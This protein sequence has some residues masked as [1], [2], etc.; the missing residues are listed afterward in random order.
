MTDTRYP[1]Y[2]TCQGHF[3]SF[4]FLFFS[5]LNDEVAHQLPFDR[6]PMKAL[7]FLSFLLLVP[8]SWFWA[9]AA[10]PRSLGASRHARRGLLG[11]SLASLRLR[12]SQALAD[13]PGAEGGTAT[14]PSAAP[15]WNSFCKATPVEGS[16]EAPPSSQTL[17]HPVRVTCRPDGVHVSAL[18]HLCVARMP[19]VTKVL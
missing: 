1:K 11:L 9:A 17:L 18:N 3:T 12:P 14:L 8:F 7:C 16:P 10:F 13:D 4:F 2:K 5:R 15:C 6:F 19:P